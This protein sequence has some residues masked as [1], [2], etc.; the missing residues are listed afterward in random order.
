MDSICSP[1]DF[2]CWRASGKASFATFLCSP[3][4][5]RPINGL[6]GLAA[7]LSTKAVDNQ[8]AG[9][10]ARAGE[11][12]HSLPCAARRMG[13]LQQKPVQQPP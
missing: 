10:K 3:T 1:S 9:R 4:W 13:A 7:G 12:G 11:E 6:G 2:P 5:A 8:A